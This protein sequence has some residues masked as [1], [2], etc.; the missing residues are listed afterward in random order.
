MIQWSRSF[1]SGGKGHRFLYGFHGEYGG[2]AEHGKAS[3]TKAEFT[4][5][6]GFLFGKMTV[7]CQVYLD[8]GVKEAL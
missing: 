5:V 2:S 8:G 1:R 3:S 6:P 7:Q 4:V